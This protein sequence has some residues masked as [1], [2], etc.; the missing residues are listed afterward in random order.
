MENILILDTSI[1]TG[2]KGDDIIMECTHKEL[3]FLL[4]DNY[5]LRLP[6]HVSSFHWYQV[7]KKSRSLMRFVNCQLKFVGGSNI[8]S[9]NMLTHYP[10]WN[11]NW[12]NSKPFQGS[13]LVGVGVG[14]GENRSNWYTRHLYSRVLSHKYIHSVRDERSKR[15]IEDELGL[16][17]INTGC[18]T[19]WIFTPEFCKTIP[20]QKTDKVVFTI[21]A[22][23]QLV[24]KDRFLIDILRSLYREIYFWPQGIDDFIYLK[25]LG[26]THDIHI[27]PASKEAYDEYLTQNETD[28]VGT[29]LH[30][31]IYAMRHHRRS[32]IIAIDERA[33]EI[34]KVNNLVCVEIDDLES[35]LSQLITSE[36]RTNIKMDFDSINNWKDQFSLLLK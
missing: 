28:Y 35:T 22:G 14:A 15:Y 9:K 32:I 7:L 26:D 34:N 18:V 23:K 31:G 29:R 19:M 6:T 33:R 5:E 13:I 10:Q 16:K 27:L 8:L 12:F 21:T 1:G 20:A 25:Q 24:E 36:F 17:A 30:G 3:D 2:N 11:I 4:H